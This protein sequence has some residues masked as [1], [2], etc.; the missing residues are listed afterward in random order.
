M[1]KHLMALRSL[2]QRSANE[3][4][5]VRATQQQ[6]RQPSNAAY[7]G[8]VGNYGYRAMPLRFT[9]GCAVAAGQRSSSGLA[10]VDWRRVR[11]RDHAEPESPRRPPVPSS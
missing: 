3:G 8:G 9:R 2:Q 4:R 1:M 5:L 7:V 6:Q 11:A 10:L